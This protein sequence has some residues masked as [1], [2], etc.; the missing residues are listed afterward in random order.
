MF[1]KLNHTAKF[2]YSLHNKV[3]Q[4]L[5]NVVEASIIIE[6]EKPTKCA[7]NMIVVH[8]PNKIRICLYPRLLNKSITHYPI[9][10]AY[11]LMTKI[12]VVRFLLFWMLRNIPAIASG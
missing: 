2:P 8:F 5:N 4:V 11:S 1:L 3:K 6:F 12:Q 10:T 9:P 7:S